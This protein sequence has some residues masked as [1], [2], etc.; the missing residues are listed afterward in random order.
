MLLLLQ[1]VILSY[2]PHN[3]ACMNEYCR[4]CKCG[5]RCS[6]TKVSKWSETKVRSDSVETSE[7]A[8][9][10]H[11]YIFNQEIFLTSYTSEED[12]IKVNALVSLHTVIVKFSAIMNMYVPE[13]QHGIWTF[14][15][16][17]VH[18]GY[19]RFLFLAV[20]TAAQRSISSS[21]LSPH[22]RVTTDTIATWHE[23]SHAIMLHRACWDEIRL[24][25]R[26]TWPRLDFP[27]TCSN[28]TSRWG[29]QRG[30]TQIWQHRV[31][32]ANH[33][34]VR[35][36]CQVVSPPYVVFPTFQVLLRARGWQ[37]R[38]FVRLCNKEYITSTGSL[39][40]N[41]LC[42]QGKLDVDDSFN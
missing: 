19:F 25:S 33:V 20:G 2:S 9:V 35:T 22:S 12:L 17:S 10:A 38:L 16:L 1:G 42:T 32:E 11:T 30:P 7:T 26:Q 28:L 27:C 14:C 29:I 34:K 24:D 4:V 18:Y 8:C 3:S 5:P 41:S 13:C 40:R 36:G 31:P 23:S 15:D 6:F 37:G 21:V 39:G